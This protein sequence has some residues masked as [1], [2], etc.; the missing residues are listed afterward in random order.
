MLAEKE[1]DCQ[2]GV[3]TSKNRISEVFGVDPHPGHTPTS[4]IV[5]AVTSVTFLMNQLKHRP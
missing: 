5:A 3:G 2:P 4:L 1:R